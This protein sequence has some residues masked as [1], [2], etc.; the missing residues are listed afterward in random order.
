VTAN[1]LCP[2][3]GGPVRITTTAFDPAPTV[4]IAAA[5]QEAPPAERRFNKHNGTGNGC[6][7]CGKTGVELQGGNGFYFCA[8][9]CDEAVAAGMERMGEAWAA[10]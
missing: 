6:D 9:G 1:H 4:T 2:T 8:G 7:A 5:E 3:C 10:S